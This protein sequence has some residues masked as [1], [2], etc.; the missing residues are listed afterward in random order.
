MTLFPL[1]E[2]IL[3]PV[4]IF[5]VTLLILRGFK[6]IITFHNERFNAID[7]RMSFQFKALMEKTE[8]KDK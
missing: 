6:Q 1:I 5:F 8:R 3:V 2:T 7:E 4:F